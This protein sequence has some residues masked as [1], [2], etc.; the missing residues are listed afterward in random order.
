MIIMVERVVMK[1]CILNLAEK[2]PAIALKKVVAKTDRNSAK[3]I[4]RP[5]SAIASIVDDVAEDLSRNI[6]AEWRTKPTQRVPKPIK[7]PTDR[8]VPPKTIKPAT[9]RA[10]NIR[11]RGSLEEAIDVI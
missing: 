3:K 1:G 10:K 8:S 5:A 7:R 2:K 9:P 4:R 6:T 11:R